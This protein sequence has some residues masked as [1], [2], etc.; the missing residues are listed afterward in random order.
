[1]AT[2]L[3]SLCRGIVFQ[4]LVLCAVKHYNKMRDKHPVFD[5]SCLSLSAMTRRN[6]LIFLVNS[7]G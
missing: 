3:Y 7:Q 2:E 5:Y 4:L 6:L 1:M